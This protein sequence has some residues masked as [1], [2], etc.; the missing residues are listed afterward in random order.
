V[1]RR[2]IVDVDAEQSS[3]REAQ[4]LFGRMKQRVF[5]KGTVTLG[6]ATGRTQINVYRRL[7]ELLRPLV[8][9]GFP[10]AKVAIYFLDEYF[11]A[12]PLYYAYA[13]QHLLVE[14][15]WGFRAENIWVP[16]GCFFTS[17]ARGERLINSDLLD[18]IL[19]ETQGQWE[20]RTEA[21]EEKGKSPRGEKQ[22][23]PAE[24]HILPGASHPVLADIRKSMRAY[25]ER[26]RTE[27]ADRIALLGLGPEGHIGFVERGTAP[28]NIDEDIQRS[29]VMLV[30]LAESTLRAN[31]A[32]FILTN[33]DGA[34]VKLERSRYAI[35]QG[36]GT[37]LS[38]RE[39]LLAAHGGSKR[40]AV[41]RML[42]EDPGPLNPAAFV[43]RHGNVTIYLDRA[44]FSG[45]RSGKLEGFDVELHLDEVPAGG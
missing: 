9:E 43:R 44:A 41:R 37:I 15:E 39:L 16:R 31:D 13:R 23:P 24:I 42:H 27:G 34:Q 18:D 28:A 29:E 5:E 17:V 1:S 10:L 25:D 7:I 21:A 26:V 2:I 36:I 40:E 22:K 14:K 30:R 33:D 32:D 6:G 35:T 4:D 45:V 3:L 38:A 19:R 20:E 8:E 12:A 11:G